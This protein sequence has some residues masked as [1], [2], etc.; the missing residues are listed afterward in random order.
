M[1]THLVR[2]AKAAAA[3]QGTTLTALIGDALERALQAGGEA[4]IGRDLL[5]RMAVSLDGPRLVL[6][7][8]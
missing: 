4:I 1:P 3:R 2:E 5:N 7:I 6:S 8:R